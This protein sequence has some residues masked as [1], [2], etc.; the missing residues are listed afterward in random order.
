MQRYFAAK[1]E[2]NQAFLREEDAH[3]LVDVVR[4]SL[5][6]KIEVVSGEK[7]F[8]GEITGLN[9]LGIILLH[10]LEEKRELDHTVT[11]AFAVLKGDHNDLIVEKGTE[12]GCSHFVPFLSERTIIKVNL[13]EADGRILRLRKIAQSS[14]QQCRRSLVP[15]VDNYTD[16]G[17]VCS[18]KADLKLFA[19]EEL[20]GQST[21]LKSALMGLKKD[22]SILIVVGPEGGFSPDEAQKAIEAGFQPISLGRRILRAETAGIASL[23][24]VSAF[25]EDD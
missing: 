7:T 22:Q 6:E 18:L 5:H 19:Y 24:L 3:H 21:T 13:G 17:T 23:S 16:F 15:S 2:G 1:V 9:P 25:S 20:A 10:S 12:L 14:A 11:L 4:I 8:L